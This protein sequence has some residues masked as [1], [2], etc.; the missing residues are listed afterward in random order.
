M[1]GKTAKSGDWPQKSKFH[2]YD[3]IEAEGL[4]GSLTS[5]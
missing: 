3:A 5:P 4:Q 2:I 1:G